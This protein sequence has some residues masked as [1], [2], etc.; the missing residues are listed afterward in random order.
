MRRAGLA[1]GVGLVVAGVAQAQVAEWA[2]PAGG[3]WADSSNWADGVLPEPWAGLVRFELDSSFSVLGPALYEGRRLLIDGSRVEIQARPGSQSPLLAWFEPEAQNPQAVLIGASPGR[4]SSLVTDMSVFGRRIAVGAAGAGAMSLSRTL[5]VEDLVVGGLAEARD[6]VGAVA[7]EGPDARM[8]RPD[9]VTSQELTIGLA[10]SGRL[11]LLNG[12]EALDVT[13]LRLGVEPGSHGALELEGAGTRMEVGELEFGLGSS[14]VTVADDASLIFGTGPFLTTFA[15]VNFSLRGGVAEGPARL[16]FLGAEGTFRLDGGS[17]FIVEDYATVYNLDLRSPGTR[18]ET[19]FFRVNGSLTLRDGAEIIVDR[20]DLPYAIAGVVIGGALI[21]N[22]RL[23]VEQV[24]GVARYPSLAL[25]G[26]QSGGGHRVEIVNGGVIDTEG[27]LLIRFDGASRISG[28]GTIVRQT[29]HLSNSW[30]SPPVPRGATYLIGLRPPGGAASRMDIADGATVIGSA[31]IFGATVHVSD[32]SLVGEEVMLIEYLSS[33]T[34]SNGGAARSPL[35]LIGQR[36][37]DASPPPPPLVR[38]VGV[39]DGIVSNAGI[40]DPGEV[41][42]AGALRIEGALR[43]EPHTVELPASLLGGPSNR[44]SGRGVLH[45]DIASPADHD[46]LEVTGD[47][48]LGGT[49][50]VSLLGG[51]APAWGDAFTV[52][53]AG[54]IDGEFETLDLPEAPAGLVYEVEY[55]DTAATLSLA[56]RTDITRDLVVG[57]E[58]LGALL[59]QWGTTDAL[60]D[61]NGDGVVDGADLG[62][63]LGDW[64][65]HAN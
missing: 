12:A 44:L 2:N 6:A 29:T 13:R 20:T 17:R 7:L 63:V 40:I 41:G 60:A 33:L 31:I 58:D 26:P 42:A 59:M 14:T 52:L 3:D 18:F 11:R 62:I 47:A 54:A 51:F 55:T 57:A 65:A 16:E 36:T 4:E 27:Q 37:T 1:A 38:G 56:R 5:V 25:G 32:A 10:G 24:D 22:A 50:E 21:D 64:G 28:M 49:L 46:R 30:P 53:T 48:I 43:M 9:D 35:L 39:L 23:I 61:V 45:I 15:N 8:I 34:L 19:Q